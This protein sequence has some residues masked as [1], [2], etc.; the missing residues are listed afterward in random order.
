[1]KGTF[2]VHTVFHDSSQKFKASGWFQN[3]CTEIIMLSGHFLTSLPD[4]L[5]HNIPRH[6]SSDIWRYEKS[7]GRRA[8]GG[9]TQC[10]G[11]H[12]PCSWDLCKCVHCYSGAELTL[13]FVRLILAENAC[14]VFSVCKGVMRLCTVLLV[15]HIL[16]KI[17]SLQS[18]KTLW[19]WSQ[20]GWWNTLHSV[21]GKGRWYI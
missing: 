15:S 11:E 9:S 17:N 16:T 19:S 6:C 13:C 18:P 21:C 8:V 14:W 12:L 3:K 2:E 10:S 5:R 4:E 20:T 1:M 7:E